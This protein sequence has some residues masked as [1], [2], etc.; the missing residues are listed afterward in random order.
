[1][2]TAESI[3]ANIREKLGMVAESCG[4]D[5][6][7]NIKSPSAS[8]DNADDSGSSINLEQ[9]STKEGRFH[10]ERQ[11]HCQRCTQHNVQNRL[12]GHKQHCPFKLCKCDKCMVVKQRQRLMADQIKARR[13]QR[14]MA[15]VAPA[16]GPATSLG[17]HINRETLPFA[18]EQLLNFSQIKSQLLLDSIKRNVS[19]PLSL[20]MPVTSTSASTAGT[21][22]PDII[23]SVPKSVSPNHCAKPSEQNVSAALTLLSLLETLQLLRNASTVPTSLPLQLPSALNLNALQI[24]ALQRELTNKAL[25]AALVSRTV[26]SSSSP[27]TS[28][29]HTSPAPSASPANSTTPANILAAGIL[30]QL[31]SPFLADLLQSSS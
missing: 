21:N 25:A 8:T 7:R 22:L 10:K 16:N 5:E 6:E 17:L 23:S 2:E 4:D 3:L 29:Q 1:M 19:S 9:S 20:E 13:R 26:T 27:V 18:P 28:A 11:P 30:Q 14:K 12:K 15:S 31:P 24:N